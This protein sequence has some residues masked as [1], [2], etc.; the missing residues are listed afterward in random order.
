MLLDEHYS[1][2][3]AQQLRKRGHDVVSASETPELKNLEDPDL[4]TWAIGQRRAVVSE[5]A[6]DFVPLHE[7]CLIRG[8]PHYGIV[9]TN[10]ERF[11]RTRAGIGRLVRAIEGLLTEASTSEALRAEL[12]WLSDK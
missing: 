9:L 10:R 2:A 8:K 1:P 5:N 6:A 3:I 11:S 12:R 7:D 4:L